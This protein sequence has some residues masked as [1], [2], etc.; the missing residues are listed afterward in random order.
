[1]GADPE[2]V[3]LIFGIIGGI[4][5]TFFYTSPVVPCIKMI[6]KELSYKNYPGILLL[7]SVFSCILWFIYG[8][9]QDELM[10]WVANGVG[11]CITEIWIL[12]YVYYFSLEV[13]WKGILYNV[14]VLG[15][16]GGIF[17]LFYIVI[18]QIKVTSNVAMVFNI[19]MY[20][21]PGE[22]MYTVIKT[23]N[24]KILPVPIS[25]CGIISSTCW[26]IYGI[27]LK[28]P[29]MIVP[30]ALGIF[31][32]TCQIFVFIYSYKKAQKEGIKG[33]EKK[34]GEGEE[35]KEGEGE[36][37]KEPKAEHKE[38][39]DNVE[40]TSEDIKK[41]DNSDTERLL[42]E[43]YPSAPE[44]KPVETPE[45]KPAEAPEEKPKEK[46]GEEA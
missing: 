9:D 18:D 19:L 33:E 3:K 20:A 4:L 40:N 45:D 10:V 42:P 34:E 35:K 32:S 37:K 22:K 36:E 29:A 26:E 46:E 25:V 16:F 38:K 2:T 15:F 28:D 7:C 30:N 1:M 14:L 21:A 44:D 8:I 5:A 6:K 41:E 11:A 43:N 39:E 13:I 27:Y 17:V 12:I 31:F 24:Y 23:N